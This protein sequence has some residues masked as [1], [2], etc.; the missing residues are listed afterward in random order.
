MAGYKIGRITQ[1]IKRE[2]SA[3]LRELKDPRIDSMLSIVKVSVSNDMSHC[4]V[5]VSA[6][7]GMDKTRESVEGLK[8]ASGFVRRELSNRLHL[9]KCPD[10]TFIADNSIEYGAQINKLLEELEEGQD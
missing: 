1:D 10:L 3:I 4:K 2:L 6:L 7:E 9:R 5:Y 8:S